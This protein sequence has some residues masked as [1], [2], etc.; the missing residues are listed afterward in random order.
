MNE[1]SIETRKDIILK[2]ISDSQQR[3]IIMCI[4]NKAKTVKQISEE[5]GMSISMTYRKINQLKRKNMLILSGNIIKN[6]REFRYQSKVSKVIIKFDSETDVRIYT[7][8]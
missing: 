3:K 6:K 1:Q 7:N 2:M 4:N 5:T 8:N